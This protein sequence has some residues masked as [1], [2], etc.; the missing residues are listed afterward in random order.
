MDLIHFDNTSTQA[1]RP[2]F[3]HPMAIQDFREFLKSKYSQ[4][5]LKRRLGFNDLRYVTPPAHE[6]PLS[7]ITD[8]LFQEWP[9]S[10]AI[11]WPTTT[12]R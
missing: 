5:N 3:F 11:S 4:E 7:T 10:A 9:I 12:G 1:R 6:A 2:I 8:P